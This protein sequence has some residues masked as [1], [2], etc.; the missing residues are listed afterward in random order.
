MVDIVI[1][2][3]NVVAGA[4]A[5][6]ETGKAGAAINAGQIVYPDPVDGSYKL[7][8]NNSGTAATR[9]PAAMALTSAAIGQPLVVAKAGP[10]T[11][12][13]VLTVGVGYYLSANAG[14]IC[15]VADLGTGKYPALIG[16]AQSTSQLT[17]RFQEAGV[18]LP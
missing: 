18:A 4:T 12:G 3:A 1:T 14:G 17:I 5:T 11:V 6:T 10:V 8:Q 15:P 7:A 16:F 9:S 2:A 13:A